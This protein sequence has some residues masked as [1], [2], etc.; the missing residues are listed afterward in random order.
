MLVGSNATP[1]KAVIELAWRRDSNMNA[2]CVQRYCASRE[3]Q[4]N[5]PH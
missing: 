2:L 3:Q 1:I 5:S 4:M